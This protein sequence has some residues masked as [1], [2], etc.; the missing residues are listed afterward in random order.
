MHDYEKPED[1][2]K[3]DLWAVIGDLS[4]D[5][6]ALIKDTKVRSQVSL[7]ALRYERLLTRKAKVHATPLGINIQ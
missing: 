7:E 2:H 3:L 4:N 5:S 6:H 1:W